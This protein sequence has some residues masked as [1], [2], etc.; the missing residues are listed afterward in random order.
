MKILGSITEM[1]KNKQM[2]YIEIINVDLY[3]PEAHS[4]F[5]I[6]NTKKNVQ[7]RIHI[8]WYMFLGGIQYCY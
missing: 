7:L 1:K 5:Q 8:M 3:R 2:C 4:S 6:Q